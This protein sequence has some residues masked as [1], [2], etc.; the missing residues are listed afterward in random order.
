MSDNKERLVEQVRMPSI[1]VLTSTEQIGMDFAKD[2]D[3]ALLG[4]YQHFHDGSPTA[5]A[6]VRELKARGYEPMTIPF[7]QANG[8]RAYE[9]AVFRGGNRVL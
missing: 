1:R 7:T 5:V 8:T 2:A 3:E 6:I 9:A 4:Y